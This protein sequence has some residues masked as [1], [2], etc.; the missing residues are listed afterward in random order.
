MSGYAGIV[1][2][3]GAGDGAE[4][5]TRRAE[6]MMAAIAFR[7]PDLQNQWSQQD[8]HF[9]FSL[10]KTG[11]APQSHSQPC[12]LD[13]YIWLLGDVRLDGREE[14]IRRFEQKGER[15]RETISDEELV[16][17]T[18]RMFGESGIVQLDGDYS[19]VLW[20]ATRKRLLGFR[21][22]TG[23]KPF[24]Y[25]ASP[26]VISFSNTM[27]TLRAAP[28]FSGVL[29][30]NFLG[31]YLLTSWCPDPERAVYRDVRRLPPGCLLE[32]SGEGFSARRIAQIP[33]EA[34]LCY[35]R[36][37]EYV[38]NYRE[39]LH[40]AVKDRLPND[41]CVVFMSGGLD[42]TAVAAEANR[43]FRR[44]DRGGNVSAQTIDYRPLFKD[45]E[46][47][48]ARRVAAYL[49]IPF[50][51]L[52]GGDCR[53][54]SGWDRAGFPMPE[55][56]HEPFQ[57]LHVESYRRAATASRVAL[58]GDGGDD[59]LLGQ[60]WPYLRSLLRKGKLFSAI[61]VLASHVWNTRT[62]PVLGLGIRSRIRNRFGVPTLTESFPEW[63]AGDFERRLN[64]RTRFKE[65]QAKP[66]SEHPTHPWAYAMLTGPFWPNVLEG[67]DAAWSGVAMERRAPLLD[68]RMVR[69]LL[70]LPA[71]PWCMDKR[72][73]RMSMKDF[74]PKE[75]VERPKMPLRQD[76]LEL[77]VSEGKWSP[78]PLG[79][80]LPVSR[81][82]VD[83]SRLENCIKVSRGDSLYSNLRPVSLNLW[84]KS[85][86]MNGRIQ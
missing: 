29:D 85:V 39:L 82:L 20:D 86:E 56:R 51:L 25:V 76:P 73:L 17:Q 61:G 79:D 27:D 62:L 54:F 4:G 41:N 42:S 46:G 72:L 26:G 14:L 5:D 31:D 63:I 13:G 74:L 37:E 55:P 30:E 21:D 66:A 32:F 43:I 67:E 28:G 84:L 9:C 36:G 69:F 24:F 47:E 60:A 38:E 52:P 34:P 8:A 49:Q 22:L 15:F 12:S 80:F 57:A 1:R 10:L 3:S 75:T 16:L 78:M 33:M 19:F 50:E 40:R 58:S 65:L 7:G 2:T 44:G 18:F 35:K 11:P 71:L 48:Q 70:R 77:H 23:S 59:V 83:A 53:P 6:K 64:L 68:R 81:E 45:E